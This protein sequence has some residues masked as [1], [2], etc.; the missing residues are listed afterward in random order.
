MLTVSVLSLSEG[1]ALGV[2]KMVLEALE[3]GPLTA[4]ELIS[5]V[6]KR[7]AAVNKARQALVGRGLILEE[8]PGGGKELFRLP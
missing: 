5:K 1:K 3:S 2:E 6:G 7:E 4:S 8:R